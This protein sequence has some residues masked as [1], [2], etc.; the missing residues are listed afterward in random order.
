MRH[1]WIGG[2]YNSNLNQWRWIHNNEVIPSVNDSS[3]F[4]PWANIEGHFE[5]YNEALMCLNLDRS[6]HV[7]AHL[8]G[9]DCNHKQPFICKISKK[10]TV[11]KI[12]KYL[13]IDM[14][15]LVKY[16]FLCRL[17]YSTGS[18]KWKL[19]LLPRTYRKS[20]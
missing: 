13:T 11:I 15:Y 12:T 6:D 18:R 17:Q 20:M 1:L 3:G 8:Y 10:S 16:S 5:F 4:P 2:R 9:L 19:E 14:H 7:K